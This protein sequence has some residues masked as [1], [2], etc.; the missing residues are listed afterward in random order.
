MF[1][2]V[3]LILVSIGLTVLGDYTSIVGVIFYGFL[4]YYFTRTRVKAFFGKGTILTSPTYPSSYGPTPGF[5]TPSPSMYVPQTT[6]T[7]MGTAPTLAIASSLPTDT[8]RTA[9][10]TPTRFCTNCGAM[11]TAGSTKC[12]SCGRTL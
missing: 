10:S 8:T 6:A 12:G 2:N 7:S 11:I 3:L 9:I 4:T 5:S 1:F